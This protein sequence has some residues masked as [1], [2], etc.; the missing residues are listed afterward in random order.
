MNRYIHTKQF[1]TKT[2][3]R[4]YSS[5]LYPE[6]SKLDIDTY[7]TANRETRLDLLAYQYYNDPE[8]YWI[9]AIT[10]NIQGTL[11]IEPG[12]QIC[13]PNRTRIGEIISK[14]ENLNR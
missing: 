9:I 13:I 3:K 12:T 14:L 6:I 4:Y 7:I 1:K 2:G 8:L 5:T 11:F 10:N